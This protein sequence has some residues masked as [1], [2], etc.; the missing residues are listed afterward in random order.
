MQSNRE[1]SGL[2]AAV[3]NLSEREQ[4][5]L[6]AMLG[7]FAV[8]GLVLIIGLAQRSL[9]EMEDQSRQYEE[10]LSLL[11]AE[12]PAYARAQTGGGGEDSSK[13]ALFTDEVLNDNPVQ[14]HSSVDTHA[15]AVGIRISSFDVDEHPLGSRRSGDDEGPMIVERQLRIDVRNA[16]MDRLVEMLHRIEESRDPVV[17]KRI[18]TR[19][20]RDE[21]KVRAL[22]VI[23]TF[24]Y[25]D[26]EDS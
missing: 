24:L 20:V 4:M 14:L 6:K 7:V 25:G 11:A 16:E 17:I 23:S 12:G 26:E 2:K 13:A 9:A 15:Q 1:V 22:V 3:A 5:M 19:S 8:L 18:D 21:G 10:V